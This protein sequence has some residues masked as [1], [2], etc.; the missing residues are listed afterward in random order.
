MAGDRLPVRRRLVFLGPP[1]CGKGTQAELLSEES[2]LPAISTGEMLRSAVAAE[3]E[4]GQRVEEIMAAGE[5]VD[6]ATMA[7]VVR[8][9]LSLADAAKGFLLDGYPR[10]LAQASTLEEIL[11]AADRSLDGVVSID[12]PTEELVR[13]A[14]DRS[15]PDDTEDVIRKRHEVYLEATEPLIEYYTGL[16]LILPIA[17]DRPI[18]EVHRSILNA[19]GVESL[20]TSEDAG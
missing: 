17:G 4:L 15:R 9:R 13:R 11:S 14:L 18:A 20:A 1:G 16:G 5:L 2:G 7:D 6:D 3:S 10:T 8:D 19:L 12:V